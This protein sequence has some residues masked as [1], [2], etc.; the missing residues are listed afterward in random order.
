MAPRY[1]D[2]PTLRSALTYRDAVEALRATFSL[3][4]LPDTPQRKVLRRDGGELLVMPAWGEQGPGVKLVTVHPSNP[5]RGLPLISGVYVLFSPDTLEPIAVFDAAALTALRT[6][7]VS[8]LATDLLAPMGARRLV[9]FGAGVQAEAHIE[10]MCSVRPISDVVVVSRRPSTAEEL[11]DR[12]AGNGLSVR[13][14]TP[15]DVRTADIVCTCTTS[16]E[17]VF[18]GKLLGPT[19][20]VNAVGAHAP[21][22][23]EVDGETVRRCLV[24]VETRE[25]ALAEAGDLLIPLEE[26]VVD[27]GEIPEWELADLVG[28][29]VAE[30]GRKDPTLFK[31]VGVAFEDLAVAHAV[32][33]NS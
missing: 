14:G 4:P 6:A 8:A 2:G 26:G 32:F 12:A 24:V 11:A 1:I 13:V 9:V 7:A 30:I 33:S 22:A 17:P 23:R 28:G 16:S 27:P 31:S 21:R 3:V 20:H 5:S 25:A 10:A 18:D 19:T 29:R 15:D